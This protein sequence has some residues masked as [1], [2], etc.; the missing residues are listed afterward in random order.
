MSTRRSRARSTAGSA[1]RSRRSVALAAVAVSAG[2]VVL[3]T[4]TSAVATPRTGLIPGDLLVSRLHYTGTPGMIVAGQT[5]LPT[6]VTANAD[7]SFANV[8]N[9]AIVD[10]NF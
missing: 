5:V 10:P 3:N 6:G 2:A 1:V 4:A 7:G 9:N 8:W